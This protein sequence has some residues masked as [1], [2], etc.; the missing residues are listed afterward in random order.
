MLSKD[1]ISIPKV[2]LFSDNS[3]NDPKNTSVLTAS[4]EYIISTKRFDAP[5]YQN[6]HLS[7]CLYAA[8]C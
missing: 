5:L 8:Y 1:D 6:R 4:I 7:I 2:L 3:F